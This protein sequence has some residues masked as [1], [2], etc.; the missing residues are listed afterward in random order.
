MRRANGESFLHA[1]QNARLIAS[2]EQY[3][4]VMYYGGAESWNLRDRHMAGTLEHLLQARGPDSKSVVWAHNLHLGNARFTEI[5]RLRNEL[6]LGQLCRERF[7][8]EVAAI[9]F[10]KDSG[11]VAAAYDWNGDME[12][13]RVRP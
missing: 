12:V 5:G 3:Y 10:G 7:G 2:A 6:S 9:G 11:T 4:R 8:D 1:A 13:M